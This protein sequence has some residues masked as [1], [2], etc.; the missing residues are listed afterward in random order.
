MPLNSDR[1]NIQPA[2][3]QDV[4]AEVLNI[5]ID[6]LDDEEAGEKWV[7]DAASDDRI[8]PGTV[9]KVADK[10]WGED[11]MVLT[12]GDSYGREQG[13]ARGYHVVSPR[14]MSKAEWARMREANAVWATS[15]RF[16]QGVAK[17][18]YI[19]RNEWTG[20]M[21]HVEHITKSIASGAGFVV[22]VEMI[23]SRDATC[24]AQYGGN[25]VT[26]NVSNLGKCWFDGDIE[27]ILRLI[28]HELGH[29][30]G[31]HLSQDYYDG[32]CK[33]GAVVAMM[34]P[35]KFER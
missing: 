11:R 17:A 24:S 15:S 4:R 23:K 5:M 2:F 1:D 21:Y 25:C 16:N 12:P 26:F 14:E 10:R 30:Y 29:E 18:E 8:E 3:L 32:L 7:R 28:I 35:A 6:D 27:E 9:L 33:I 22:V 20:G 19:P 31:H 34:D 13:L